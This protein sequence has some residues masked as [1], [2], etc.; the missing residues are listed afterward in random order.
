[1][2]VMITITPPTGASLRASRLRARDPQ[3]CHACLE[4]RW[5]QSQTLG[6][7]VD[8]ADTPATALDDVED[9]LLFDIR[10]FDTARGCRRRPGGYADGEVIADSHDHRT[11]H[12]VP[13]LADVARPWIAL[14]RLHVR[15]RNGVDPLAE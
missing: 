2:A 14:Q 1:M 13:Q 3:L 5:P 15:S 9:V 7:T 4:R 10:Q 8:A 11:L 12:D 6:R